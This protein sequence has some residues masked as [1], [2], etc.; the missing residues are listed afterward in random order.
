MIRDNFFISVDPDG[1]MPNLTHG[2]PCKLFWVE[3]R[4]N[5]PVRYCPYPKQDRLWNYAESRMEG[6]SEGVQCYSGKGDLP[7][8]KA[9]RVEVP[10]A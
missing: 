3:Y 10:D 9:K 1:N 6:L 5:Q 2:K 7:V 4:N 8:T